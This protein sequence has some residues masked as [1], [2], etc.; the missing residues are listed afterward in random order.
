[1]EKKYYIGLDVHKAQTTYAVKDWNGATIYHGKSATQFADLKRALNK[2]INNSVIVME[3]CTNYY[4]L[5]K[6]MKEEKRDV[7][8]AN[9][10]RL[11]KF[12]GKKW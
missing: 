11:R 7:H 3:A 10:I 2:Y 1:M 6:Q 4:H 8:V 5:Y 12:I 9:V